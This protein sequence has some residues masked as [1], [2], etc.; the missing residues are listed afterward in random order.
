MQR[1]PRWDNKEEALAA[2]T[3]NAAKILGIDDKTGSIEKGKDANIVV[4]KGDILDVKGNTI[5]Y[6]YIQG[7]QLNLDNKQKQLFEKFKYKYGIK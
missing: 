1:K 4:S 5:T 3:L 6:A 7:R 2:I